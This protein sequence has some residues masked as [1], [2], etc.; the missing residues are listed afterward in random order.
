[1]HNLSGRFLL[2]RVVHV[3]VG[4][5]LECADEDPLLLNWHSFRMDLLI[6]DFFFF[7]FEYSF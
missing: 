1:M 4:K 3:D 7:F 2:A 5:V 6:I